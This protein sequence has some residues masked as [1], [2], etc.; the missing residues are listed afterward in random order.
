[1]AEFVEVMNIKH[2]MDNYYEYCSAGCPLY[3]NNFRSLSDE[4]LTT[5]DYK[6]AEK[7]MLKWAAEHPVHPVVYPMWVE[8]LAEQRLVNIKRLPVDDY[9]GI[10]TQI[11]PSG[12]MYAHIP[13]DIAQKL[14]IEPKEV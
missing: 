8:W 7:I 10:I 11:E 2:R 1:M 12:E 3:M 6:E 13:A 9:G 4:S 14:G 5:E